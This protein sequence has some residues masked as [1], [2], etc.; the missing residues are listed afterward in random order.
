MNTMV[1]E[2]ARRNEALSVWHTLTAA[3]AAQELES[4]FERG[5]SAN[6]AAR[7]LE[8]EGPNEFRELGRRNIFAMA[9]SQFKD[10]MVLVLIAAAIVSGF[11][12]DAGDTIV[13]MAIVVLNAAI[14]FAQDYRAERAIAALKRLAAMQA[15]VVRDGRRTIAAADIV[16]GDIV[17]LEAGNAVPADLRLSEAPRLK[18]NSRR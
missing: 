6:E 13:I 8:K 3:A 17:L 5:L 18:V 9:V 15:S 1:S 4:N 7:R 10:F 2:F 12:G 16:P 14:G 11:I